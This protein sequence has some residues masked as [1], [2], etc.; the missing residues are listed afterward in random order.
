MTDPRAAMNDG[1]LRVLITHYG[2]DWIRGSETLLLD[3][4]RNLDKDQ[5]T[6]VVWCNALSIEREVKAAG[7]TAIRTDMPHALHPGSKWPG[8]AALTKLHR[9]GRKI[10]RTHRIQVLHAN[11]AAPG[12]FLV[13]LAR[14]ERLPVL[15]YLM[16]DYL[17]RGRYINLLHLMTR[18]VGISRGSLAG[19]RQD[20]VPDD[21]T[22]IIFAGIDTARFDRPSQNLRAEL[23]IPP[24]SFV[25]ASL[26]SLIP[27]KGHD[28]LV[29]A[30]AQ[31]PDMDPAPRLLLASCGPEE[32]ALRDLAR[33]LG[34]ADR[35]L[36][37]GYVASTGPVF[38]TA[39]VFSLASRTEGFGL[40]FAE[41]GHFGLPVV[42]TTVGGI[43]E[44]VADGET[45][46]LVPPNDVTALAK[47]LGALAA[48]PVLRARMGEA[49]RTRVQRL[50]TAE[51]MARA[52]E[53]TYHELARQPRQSLGWSGAPP[54]MGPYVNMV[55]SLGRRSPR[56]Y[57]T[58]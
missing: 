46:L 50:F 28:V 47:A 51:T 9:T 8:V 21:Q 49:A 36:M 53:T 2:D 18:I 57:T 45:G 6:P 43:P 31:L 44:V 29:R 54:G 24:Q 16:V 37:P 12:Q 52:F 14:R 1:P 58:T 55:R 40:V 41:A 7:F 38:R 27:R 33:S 17:R 39:D 11:G 32:G 26:G 20:G 19:L 4:I 15:A 5:V 48:D 35:V 10:I 3:L 30:F 25:I 22:S 23:G 13:P 56:G 34:V 42:A